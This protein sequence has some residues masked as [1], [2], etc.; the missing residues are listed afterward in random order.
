MKNNWIVI[1]PILRL[2][3]VKQ[4]GRWIVTCKLNESQKPIMFV[5]NEFLRKKFFFPLILF[6]FN[7]DFYL[8]FKITVLIFDWYLYSSF[9]YSLNIMN[10]SNVHGGYRVFT[11]AYETLWD[12]D[13]LGL[14]E[15][16]QGRGR[17]R[18]RLSI[19]SFSLVQHYFYRPYAWVISSFLGQ[20]FNLNVG[21]VSVCLVPYR[22]SSI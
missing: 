2:Y 22:N 19:P 13:V 4:I 14:P 12:K 11:K 17:G 21:G 8:L 7:D 10:F 5:S 20:C 1:I 16:S 9:S 15:E 6:S 18:G 3:G